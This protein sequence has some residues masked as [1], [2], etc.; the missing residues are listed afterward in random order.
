MPENAEPGSPDVLPDSVIC[1]LVS[2]WVLLFAGRWVLFNFLLADGLMTAAQAAA[3][4]AILARL[5]LALLC[6]TILVLVLRALRGA[7]ATSPLLTSEQ[8]DPSEAEARPDSLL[9]RASARRAKPRD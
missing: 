1:L 2:A 5:Y 9:S 7:R 4:D 6:I 8:S 3:L